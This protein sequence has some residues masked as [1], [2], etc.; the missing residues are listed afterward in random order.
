M[1]YMSLSRAF[2]DNFRQLSEE[3]SDNNYFYH[4]TSN[5]S[6]FK[7]LQSASLWASDPRFLNDSLEV[8][9]GQQSCIE[10]IRSLRDNP[11]LQD[12]LSPR[13]VLHIL[14]RLYN[15]F[16][17]HKEVVLAPGFTCIACFSS[18]P[19]DLS[20]WRAYTNRNGVVLGFHKELLEG[21]QVESKSETSTVIF[22][23]VLYGTKTDFVAHVKREITDTLGIAALKGQTKRTDN[24]QTW[25][26]DVSED[27]GFSLWTLIPYIKDVSFFG[28][29]EWR[30]VIREADVIKWRETQAHNVPFTNL[31]L[32]MGNEAKYSE[33]RVTLGPGSSSL[34]TAYYEAHGMQ[35]KLSEV[36]YRTS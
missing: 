22:A 13:E 18:L 3:T 21:V 26:N 9:L 19:D 34:A 36:P 17:K 8:K 2:R 15:Y 33:I 10:A 5:L 14:D 24:D 12:G 20:Q 16:V 27:L 6:A 25:L 11:P 1:D 29:H 35:V 4:Y 28:E 30:L 32:W 7:I 31:R 23:P